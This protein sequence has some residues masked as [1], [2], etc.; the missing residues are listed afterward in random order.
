MEINTI[1]TMQRANSLFLFLS[2]SFTPMRD[3]VYNNSIQCVLELL[4]TVIAVSYTVILVS[5]LVSYR[6]TWN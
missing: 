2:H 5:G 3:C 6:L 1:D 4:C